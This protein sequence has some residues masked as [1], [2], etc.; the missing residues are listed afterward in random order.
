MVNLEDLRQV[1]SLCPVLDADEGE[2][3]RL[4]GASEAPALPVP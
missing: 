2:I 3:Y 1:V 4:C